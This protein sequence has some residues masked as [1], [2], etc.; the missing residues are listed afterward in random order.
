MSNQS[1]S[2]FP[3]EDFSVNGF[4]ILQGFVAKCTYE[5]MKSRMVELVSEWTPDDSVD[6]VFTTKGSQG[7][8]DNYFNYSAEKI[9]FF[10]EEDAIDDSCGRIKHGIPKSELVN[11]AGHGL[12]LSDSVFREYSFS[13]KVKELVH[14]LGYKDPVIPQSMYIFKQPRIGGQ[15]RSHQDSTFLHT[16]PELSCLGLWLAL[17]D[18][19]LENGCLWVRE[20]S[21]KET[22]RRQYVRQGETLGFKWLN[23]CKYED[24]DLEDPSK[25]GFIPVPVKAGDLVVIHGSLDHMSQANRSSKARHSF[26]LH[27]VEGPK[28]SIYW[29]DENWLQYKNGKPF[30]S[31]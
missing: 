15:V 11:K 8:R 7:R 3:K 14:F 13:S 19:D 6:S 28:S 1:H 26:Q 18:A 5:R 12:H 2:N 24:M 17:D 30:V 10:L 9:S 31:L 16:Y 22:L 29:S 21:H 4:C 20:G 27:L 25:C 23:D